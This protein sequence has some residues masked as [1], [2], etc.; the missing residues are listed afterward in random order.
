MVR[1]R[2]EATRKPN[3]VIFFFWI[4][5]KLTESN[6]KFKPNFP[7]MQSENLIFSIE[8]TKVMRKAESFPQERESSCCWL[9][10]MLEMKTGDSRN[11][12]GLNP[13]GIVMLV[14]DLEI[15][16]IAGDMSLY[17]APPPPPP[18][19]AELC[20]AVGSTV[21]EQSTWSS[22]RSLLAWG[23]SISGEIL[24]RGREECKKEKGS[25]AMAEDWEL[26]FSFVLSC[27]LVKMLS[28]KYWLQT[29]LYVYLFFFVFNL[30]YFS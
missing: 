29:P 28:E 10:L 15:G 2:T 12:V 25:S 23:R 30:F 27:V 6:S 26:L 5:R 16:S 7:K 21:A 8:T 1:I 11:D 24:E 19:P 13:E 3:K 22:S 18:P 14:V 17:L 20:L 9:T 4:L